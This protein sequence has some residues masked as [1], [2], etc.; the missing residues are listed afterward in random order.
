[1]IDI[2]ASN[3]EGRRHCDSQPVASRWRA[4]DRERSLLGARSRR[5]CLGRLKRWR[6]H[7]Q[8]RGSC[9]RRG[10]PPPR[11]PPPPSPPPPPPPP[12]PAPRRPP[13]PP[14]APPRPPPPPPTAR[15]AHR[16]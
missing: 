7:H 14:L 3:L 1:M 6:G 8:R 16:A 10:P 11:T 9:C 15:P 5:S 12:P 4:A 2:A 13:T